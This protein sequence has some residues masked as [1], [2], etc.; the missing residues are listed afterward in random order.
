MSLWSSLRQMAS[1]SSAAPTRCAVSGAAVPAPGGS[2]RLVLYKFDSCPYC[3]RVM[4]QLGALGLSEAVELRDILREPAARS[5]LMAATGMG[6]V[7]C[8]FIDEAPLFESSDIL[9]WLSH[10]A[11]A[12]RGATA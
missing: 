12:R 1:A 6:Q 9:A 5:S 3:Q 4:R 7:P 8:L 11:A 10:H 2:P